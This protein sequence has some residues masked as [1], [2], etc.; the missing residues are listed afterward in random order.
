MLLTFAWLAAWVFIDRW[1]RQPNP[2]FVADGIPLLGWYA[3]AILCQAGLLK[4]LSSPRPVLSATLVL[5]LGLMPLPLLLVSVVSYNLET[6][7]YW[8]ISGAV[9]CYALVYLTRGLRAVTGQSQRVAAL[10]GVI[11][12]IAFMWLSDSLNAIPDL[13]NPRGTDA[14]VAD[15]ELAVRETALFEQA[16]R[17]DEALESVHRD[18][19]A[20]PNAD[21]NPDAGST[22]VAFF[23]G[24]AG[25]GEQKVF[26]QEIALASRVLGERFGIGDRHLSLVNDERDLE[27]APIA[28]VSGLA[29]ALKGLGARMNL[30]RD[31]LILSISSHGSEDPVIAVSNSE[32]PLQSLKPMEL[33]DALRESG[34]K[35]RVIIISAC[36]AGGFINSLR[37]PQTIVITAA[38]V[39]RSSFGCS[40]DNE[41][42]YFGEAFYRDAL[43]G[44][45]S[46]RDAFD[47]AKKAITTRERHEHETP[48]NPQAY[49]GTEM[50]SKLTAMYR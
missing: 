15:E 39:D 40:N 6:P 8:W 13:W 20:S 33:A 42:T 3:V 24:F 37:D 43:P 21:A 17:I 50:E 23:L 5:A 35:W 46:L 12:V 16:G 7:A 4:R 29:Y 14:Q 10:M 19:G 9:A 30:D 25:V 41:L 44:A 22:P 2:E 34:I 28:S 45:K 31:V 1:Q 26:A 36:Y 48:S 18:V 27:R 32:F 49:F 47:T 38:A 11:F